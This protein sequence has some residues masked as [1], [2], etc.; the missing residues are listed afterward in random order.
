MDHTDFDRITKR[1][2]GALTRR[3]GIRATIGAVIGLGA[4]DTATPA[5]ANVRATGAPEPEGPCGDGG[6]KDNTCTSGKD[7]CTGI[8]KKH[9]GKSSKKGGTGEKSRKGRCRCRKPG[10]RCKVS[11]NCCRGRKCVNGRCAGSPTPPTQPIATGQAC[12]AGVNTCADSNAS[13]TTYSAD[14]QSIFGAIPG[15]YCL[16]PKDA[17]GC[18]QPGL[19]NLSCDSGWCAPGATQGAPAICGAIELVAAS[20]ASTDSGGGNTIYLMQG[21]TPQFALFCGVGEANGSAPLLFLGGDGTT[22]PTCSTDADCGTGVV[23]PNDG[24]PGKVCV[25]NSS[26]SS[27]GSA[28]GVALGGMCLSGAYVCSNSLTC[29]SFAGLNSSCVS[30]PPVTMN[31]CKYTP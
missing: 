23:W 28:I 13:C 17:P 30:L 16:L 29:P 12:V 31:L 15:T 10:K 5:S 3:A 1:L 14:M 6:S 11:K 18:G 2:A 19:Q 9:S 4:F 22:P 7:C 8:C 25:S 27:F 24:T 21:A 20:S 26:A